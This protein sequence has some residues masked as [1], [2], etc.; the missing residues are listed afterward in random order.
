MI[1]PLI[2]CQ[3]MWGRR[4]V[5]R[6]IRVPLR[7]RM[8][9]KKRGRRAGIRGGR[10]DSGVDADT[11][12]TSCRALGSVQVVAA[13]PAVAAVEALSLE[14]AGSLG[15]TQEGGGDPDRDRGRARRMTGVAGVVQRGGPVLRTGQVCHQG[16]PPNEQKRS[17]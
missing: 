5:S 10:A 17:G 9:I 8:S 15:R 7:R 16:S 6:A 2:A 3:R 13:V 4:H 1:D 14:Q 11:S 12:S